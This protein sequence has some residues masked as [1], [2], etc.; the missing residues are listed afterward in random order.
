[1]ELFASHCVHVQ[2]VEGSHRVGPLLSGHHDALPVRNPNAVLGRGGNPGRK[3]LNT[4]A[5]IDQPGLPV[6]HVEASRAQTAAL[7]EHPGFGQ[8]NRPL[9]IA[10]Q[11]E[12]SLV[13]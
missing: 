3:R 6:L 4:A 2:R 12:R 1:M 11:L 5:E 9:R 8:V 7:A 13:P 10:L